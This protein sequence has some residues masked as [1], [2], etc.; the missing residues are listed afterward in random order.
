M[1]SLFDLETTNFKL[2]RPIQSFLFTSWNQPQRRSWCIVCHVYGELACTDTLEETVLQGDTSLLLSFSSRGSSKKSLWGVF[3]R[4]T[5]NNRRISSVRWRTKVYSAWKAWFG[6]FLA[7][8]L[9]QPLNTLT[10]P[11]NA[12]C[13][14]GIFAM[15]ANLLCTD[16]SSGY[17][18]FVYASLP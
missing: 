7:H 5:R 16:E 18:L 17:L 8:I 15:L 9:K 6:C 11:W 12:D 10:L 1:W 14:H 3:W 2:K 13:A 4:A